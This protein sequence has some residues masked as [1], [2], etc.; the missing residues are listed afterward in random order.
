LFTVNW[1][2]PSDAS[3]ILRAFYKLSTP[4]EANSDTTSTA[5]ATQPFS[6]NATQEGGQMLYLW[7]EDGSKNVD[8]RNNASVNLR[9]DQ[10]APLA[11]T[12]LTPANNSASANPQP[13]FSWTTSNDD[14]GSGISGYEIQIDNNSDFSSPEINDNVNTT[15]LNIT[16]PLA[17]TTW[18]WRVQ[19][20][21][22]AGNS[23]VWSVA[24][25]FQIDTQAP[26]VISDL[27]ISDTNSTSITLGWTAPGD[28]GNRGTAAQYDLRYSKNAPGTNTTAWW[29]SATPVSGLAVPHPAGT[30]EAFTVTGLEPE[31]TYYFAIKT[32]DE[33]DNWSTLSAIISGKTAAAREA[34]FKYKS[35]TGDS[36]SLVIEAA[37]IE[38]E[39][40]QSEDEIGVFTPG[41]LCV[42]AAV[43]TGQLPIMLTA[44]ADDNQTTEIDGYK[45]GDPIAFRIWDASANAELTATAT[46]SIGNGTFGNGA[47][48][49]IS[50]LQAGGSSQNFSVSGRVLYYQ[51]SQPV[52][53]TEISLN[54]SIS[55]KDTTGADGAYLF[56]N[57]P[58][59]N[60]NLIPSKAV[61]HSRRNINNSD[62]L[63]ILKKTA[64]LITFTPDQLIAGDVT[65]DQQVTNSDAQAILRYTAFYD[66]Y[67]YETGK[68]LFAPT[69]L[70]I[71]LSQ[72]MN[73]Q[74]FKAWLRG[75]VNGNW[76]ASALAKSEAA[77]QWA[78]LNL[79]LGVAVAKPNETIRIPVFV[80]TAGAG[81][82]SFNFLFHYDSDQLEYQGLQLT[83]KTETWLA[84]DNAG[85]APGQLHVAIIGL[86]PVENNGEIAD[87]LFR[88]KGQTGQ[89]R[90]MI[91][92]QDA[93][94]NDFQI[95]NLQHGSVQ[96]T[97]VPQ[98]FE[99]DQNYPNP[100]NAETLIRYHL[101]QSSS[102]NLIQVQL[103]LFNI[104]GQEVK[105]LVN[106]AQEPGSYTVHWDGR[107]ES[108]YPLP[109]GIYFYQLIAGKS[110]QHRIAILLK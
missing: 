18:S 3:G 20:T 56:Q 74:N 89:P 83:P 106:Q 72:N 71:N 107:G 29:N 28:N 23:G 95:A 47:Y 91:T 44:W 49:K 77:P 5:P 58:A 76:Q 52:S 98:S 19:A 84:A 2:N 68:W 94:A 88:V 92:F 109:S 6:L 27:A 42:G 70:N 87:L 33:V 54:G 61:D 13:T 15:S 80:E 32:R 65:G 99:L 50:L 62:A 48:S 75:D 16:N 31:Q 63:L 41:G 93:Y 25:N 21:D 66:S 4:P 60:I 51:A 85:N 30:A 46:W 17:D 39:P 55:Q 9:F 43:W 14:G 7:L 11:P 10:T 8:Y 73:D 104:E 38:N 57:I 101:P 12:L 96:F 105:T 100:F 35:N 22:S 24:W 108:G 45:T 79:K 69:S 90:S 86:K 103:K 37:K 64:F 26:A 102:G 1:T 67:I 53:N 34:H 36:Y 82:E 59:G 81:I 40:L 110:R 97:A 78:Y